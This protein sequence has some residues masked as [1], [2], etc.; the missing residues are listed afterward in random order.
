MNT[1]KGQ[2]TRS[3][4]LKTAMS[5]ININGF[6][7][8]RIND[9]IEATGVKKGNLYF[10]FSSKEEIAIALIKKA[11]DEYF[12][13]LSSRIKSPDP[14]GKIFD[15]LNAVLSLHRKRKF[16]GGC[17]FGNIALE[18]S[19]A[20]PE[21]ANLIRDVF[22]EWVRI[23]TGYLKKAGEN[24]QLEKNIDPEFMARH[25]V[26]SLEGGI[27]MAKLNKK[28][29]AILDSIRAFSILLGKEEYYKTMFD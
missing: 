22:D 19:D 17:I 3:K 24:G 28:A 7:N 11:K 14:I 23:L 18:M 27:M 9:I 26:A 16:V 4:V 20:N 21:F 8:T 12:A 29:D 6:N 10:H 25:I 1:T 2:A 5:L 15:I 13:Y